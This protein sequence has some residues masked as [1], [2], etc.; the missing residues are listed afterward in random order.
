M[1]TYLLAHDLGT[2]GDKATLFDAEGRLLASAFAPYATQYPRPGW[3]EH[4][5]EDWWRAVCASTR[6]LL[7]Q[8]PGA[9]NHLAAVG[10]SAMM[11]GCLLVDA[12]GN[13]LRPGLIHA[14]IRS[15]AQCARIAR[16][17]GGE[18]AYQLT[19]NRLA[20]YFTLGK[21]AWLAEHE[22]ETVRRA[23]WC[24]Q[25][26]EY[27]AGRLTGAWGLT[28][29]SDASLT[30]CFDLERGVWAEELIAAGGFPA[31]LLP[32][33]RPSASIVGTVTLAAAEATGLP[34]GLPVVLGGGDG[35][36]AT[37]GAGAVR[38][39]DAYH[40]LGGTSWVAAVTANY[41]PDPGRRVSVFCGLDPAQYVVYGTVQTASVALDW[42][43]NAIGVG[44]RAAGEE[45]HAALERLAASAPAGS[46]GLFF[47][48]YLQGERSP[49]WDANAR[50]VYF[51]LT[52][53]HGRT[54]LARAIMEGVAYALA[55]NLAVLEE[56]GL[57]PESIRVLGGG[58]RY[59]LWRK[60]FAAVY[61][62]PLQLLARLAEA[63][64]CGAAMIAGVGIGLY[65][66]LATAAPLF[67][68]LAEQEQPDRE[69]AA[70]YARAAAF[71]RTLYP[72][73]SDRFAELSRL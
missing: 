66:D 64:S 14:D 58:M 30:G 31:R 16:E 10:F 29:R 61:N 18:R 60:I 50:G 4:D 11:N 34:A 28:D 13:A 23:R 45:E 42:F 55:S 51:G 2:T 56:L 41:R 8:A 20:P 46:N 43:R 26:K 27:I 21:L 49:I 52:Q 62:R 48:P 19:G 44:E 25:T 36:C 12:E 6:Q 39:G 67:A 38:P 59:A 15:A 57:A 9:V 73:L 72:A 7:E 68:P 40:Y 69:A 32:T 22:P 35:A 71:F 3:A 54:E 37:A 5:P 53:A 63:T 17:V 47:L 65:P 1:L 70:V 24:V 33:V